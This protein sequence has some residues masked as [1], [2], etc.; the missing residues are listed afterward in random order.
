MVIIGGLEL[1]KI[2]YAWQFSIGFHQ[3]NKQKHDVLWVISRVWL[4]HYYT[5]QLPCLNILLFSHNELGECLL[6][7]LFKSYYYQLV[8]LNFDCFDL[9]SNFSLIYLIMFG[10]TDEDKFIQMCFDR[11]DNMLNLTFNIVNITEMLKNKLKYQDNQVKI[12][13]FSMKSRNGE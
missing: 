4:W 9:F 6:T 3:T 12:Q 1:Y 10:I 2:K 7:L 11:E 8:N 13:F 5:L